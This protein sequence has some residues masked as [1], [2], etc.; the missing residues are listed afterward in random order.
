MLVVVE[1]S[2]NRTDS[3]RN[4]DH[5]EL[6][7]QAIP[8]TGEYTILLEFGIK[9]IYK[10]NIVN[11]TVQQPICNWDRLDDWISFILLSIAI[12][13]ILGLNLELSSVFIRFDAC[14]EC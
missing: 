14:E 7:M 9:S 11:N 6:G 13:L 8:I 4:N 3:I 10:M 5:C 12:E 1:V 2:E